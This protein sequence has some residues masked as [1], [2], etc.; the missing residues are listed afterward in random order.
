MPCWVLNPLRVLKKVC[1]SFYHNFMLIINSAEVIAA[2]TFPGPICFWRQYVSIFASISAIVVSIVDYYS[3]WSNYIV[4]NT[5][6]SMISLMGSA[7]A[8]WGRQ[9]PTRPSN[10]EC[11]NKRIG[12]LWGMGA[13]ICN[14]LGKQKVKS[15]RYLHLCC[16]HFLLKNS[17]SDTYDTAVCIGA[18]SKHHVRYDSFE[19]LITITKPGERNHSIS[20]KDQNTS[21]AVKQTARLHR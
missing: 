21:N 5:G 4:A 6:P 7:D 9:V 1:L 19:S 2:G 17:V 3:R 10:F 8:T 20:I 14:W 15:I 18:L 16:M 12:T 11:Q 13:W